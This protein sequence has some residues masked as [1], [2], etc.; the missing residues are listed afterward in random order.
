MLQLQFAL[1]MSHCKTNWLMVGCKN[2]VSEGSTSLK[3]LLSSSSMLLL[4]WEWSGVAVLLPIFQGPWFT[5]LNFRHVKKLQMLSEWLGQADQRSLLYLSLCSRT[6]ILLSWRKKQHINLLL[7]LHSGIY[8][9]HSLTD[10]WRLSHQGPHIT[11]R[12][13]S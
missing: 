11:N 13:K 4:T 2:T 1:C 6:W 9:F 7:L 5:R 10:N 12:I 3:F 8:A